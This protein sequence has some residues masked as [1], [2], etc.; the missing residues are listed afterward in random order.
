MNPFVATSPPLQPET[1]RPAHA[2][3]DDS[4]NVF[5]LLDDVAT[6]HSTSNSIS[7][8]EQSGNRTSL[9]PDVHMGGTDDMP[10]SQDSNITKADRQ[11]PPQ[12]DSQVAAPPALTPGLSRDPSGRGS[13]ASA[14]PSSRG[15]KMDWTYEMRYALVFLWEHFPR[16]QMREIFQY[17]Y[18]TEIP[19][20]YLDSEGVIHWNILKGMWQTR[21]RGGNGPVPQEWAE[22][23]LAP[24]DE[25]E[26][27]RRAAIK[28][29]IDAAAVA[30]Q[31]PA[32]VPV[33]NG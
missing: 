15:P 5:D 26:R 21:T 23:A 8:Q 19:R 11:R 28:A 4:R 30:V 10:L 14:R 7:G 20:G 27:L 9:S 1:S 3:H 17:L 33:Q 22:I 29:K 24:A 18:R 2:V 16:Q 25:A 31:N 6:A 32:A 13:Q 12:P